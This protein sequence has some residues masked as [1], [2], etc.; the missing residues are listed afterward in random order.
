MAAKYKDFQNIE[1]PPFLLD[2]KDSS[3]HND[4]TASSRK[5][6]PGD[7]ALVVW[8]NPDKLEERE[9]FENSKY[10]VVLENK[11]TGDAI[12]LREANT[13]GE[14]IAAIRELESINAGS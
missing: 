10:I 11:E 4:A 5:D 3:W 14:A 6:L 7:I 12:E 1:I 13:D 9:T 8:V 2:W